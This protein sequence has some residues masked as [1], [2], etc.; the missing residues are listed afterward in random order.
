MRAFVAI[1]ITDS[2]VIDVIQKFQKEIKIDARPVESKNFHFTLQFIGEIT[3]EAAK[4]I[5]RSLQ[6]IEFSSFELVLKGIGVFPK[7]ESPRVVWIGTDDY[8][9]NMLVEIAEKVKRVLEPQGFSP[10]KPF[11]PHITIFRIKKR[12]GDISK[13]L[14]NKKTDNFGIQKVS[15]IKFKKSKLTLAGPVYSDLMEIDARQ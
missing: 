9:A 5:G 2:K 1:E 3:E 15:K 6:E 14:K 13:E 10:D 4:K 12:V 11:K 8:G 7:P